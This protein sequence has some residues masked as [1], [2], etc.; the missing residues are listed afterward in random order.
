MKKRHR[1]GT[2]LIDVLNQRVVDL[3][4]SREKDDVAEFLKK[5][6]DI[7]I[8]VR[9]GSSTYAAAISEAL[10][11]ALQI[12][13]RFHILMHLTDY[14]KD[15]INKTVKANEPI[16]YENITPVII[17]EFETKY[18]KIMAAKALKEQGKSFIEISNDLFISEMTARKYVNMN[19][20]EAAKYRRKTQDQHSEESANSKQK[21]F[22]EIH[23]LHKQ[24]L[25]NV[26]ISRKV[27]TTEATV[28]NYLKLNEP[29]LRAYNS[30]RKRAKIEP[31]LPR[32]NEL[33][34]QG[35]KNKEIIQII[36]REGC[37]CG[38]SYISKNI[39][40]QR[41]LRFAPPKKKVQR[42]AL[43]SLLYRSL[44]K[45]KGLTEEDLEKIIERYPQLEELYNFVRSFKEILFSR[46]S[47]LLEAWLDTA[48]GSEIPELHSFVKGIRQDLEATKAAIKYL[49]S[50]G[51]SEGN[52]NKIK[53]IKRRMFGR[54]SFEL[55]RAAVL[56]GQMG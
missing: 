51:I 2:V 5:Y 35:L 47:E 31:F 16:E 23:L 48:E 29:P 50:N 36:K 41:K 12:M 46:K 24:G 27:G 28:S 17:P 13:D 21:L 8:L 33:G 34:M 54:C 10:P 49:Y 42:K 19:E 3:I 38:D 25:T 7:K 11:D 14:C 26:A 52:V 18:D 53:M 39:T 44:D 15:F 43:I 40:E 22:D 1:Y 20:Q 4:E 56:L 45:V 37:K 30:Q 9:D 6:P 32:I 55:L